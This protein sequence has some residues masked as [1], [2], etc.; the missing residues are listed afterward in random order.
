MSANIG[1][2][3]GNLQQSGAIQSASWPD[4][5][6]VTVTANY[7]PWGTG[8]GYWAQRTMNFPGGYGAELAPCLSSQAATYSVDGTVAPIYEPIPTPDG[9]DPNWWTLLSAR[10]QHVL[11]AKAVYLSTTFPGY[12]PTI[13]AAIN[14]VFRN[15][16]LR[17]KVEA[18]Y[19]ANDFLNDPVGREMLA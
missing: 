6:L 17:S 8:L 18:K 13:G 1:S 3:C 7:S 9:V 19:R 2:N 4:L 10:E 15:R 5:P 12:Y 16:M 11:Y 14:E